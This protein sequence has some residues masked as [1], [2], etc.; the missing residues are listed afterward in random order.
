MNL[1][2]AGIYD[3]INIF[4]GK[5]TEAHNASHGGIINNKSRV[6][7][8]PAYQRPYRWTSDNILRLFQDYDENNAEYFLGS[9]VVVERERENTIELDVVDGQQRITTLYLLNYIRFLLKREYVLDKL[10]N[11]YQP[12]SSE[13][14]TGLKDCYVDLCGKNSVPF[15]NIA[16]KINELAENED[17]DPDE[18]VAQL[19]KCYKEELCIPDKKE[20]V[21]QTLEER[22][23]KAHAFLDNDQL[24]LKYS[25]HRYDA[26]LKDALCNVYLRVEPETNNFELAMIIQE[27]V[28][29]SNN[30]IEAMKTIFKCIWKKAIEIAKRKNECPSLKEICEKAIEYSDEI[31]KNMSLCI[32]LTENENDANKLFE[33]LNDRAL[34]VEDLE[35]IKNHFYKEYCTKSKDTEEDKDKHIAELDEVWADKIFSGNAA[36]RNKLISYLA[37]VYLTGNDEL[38]FKDDKKIKGYIEKYYSSEMRATTYEYNDIAADFNVYYAIKIILEVF[39]IKPNNRSAASLEAEQSTFSI[40][41]KALN[42]LNALKYEAVIP[43]ITN[44]II[45]SYSKTHSMSDAAFDK[46]FKEYVEGIKN[47]KTPQDSQYTI[48]HKCAFMLWIAAI[49]GKDYII[50]REI[51]KRIITKYSF[52]NF[53]NDQV[54]FLGDEI[55][56][57][58]EGLDAWLED[59]RYASSKTFAIK[60]LML[61]LLLSTRTPYDDGYKKATVK[62]NLQEAL[63]YKLDAG[64]LQLDHLEANIVD[65]SNANAYYLNDDR[66]KRQKAVNQYIGNFMIID[67]TDN[68]QKNNAPLAKAVSYY[69]KINKSWLVDDIN[70]MVNDDDF[71]ETIDGNRV[72]KEKFFIT[73]TIHLKKYFRALL[74][75]KFS[76]TEF[77]VELN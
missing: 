77:S 5:A 20:T 13:Y 45:A 35:L 46:D 52:S 15:D 17:M 69:S 21:Q 36:M 68:N 19:V 64:K 66:E 30:Y 16:K 18:R 12:K 76:Q 40:T 25:R 58:N 38:V 6:I 7:N 23:I 42:L 29:F 73:R 53:S 72:P 28:A 33:V 49:K 70:R 60:V 48:I 74:N 59:W 63:T 2:D 44:V 61:N 51:S 57:L 14:C 65:E 75:R 1:K 34:E 31:I 27:D 26:V 62:I 4:K 56:E 71:F 55:S 32:V 47:D 9:A 10:S 37:A 22:L 39:G 8:I 50:S 43:A 67:A 41:H 11:P 54:D 24:C 3:L